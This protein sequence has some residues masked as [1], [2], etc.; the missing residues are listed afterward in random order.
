MAPKANKLL[1]ELAASENGASSSGPATKKRRQLNRRD[2]ED[3]VSRNIRDHFSDLTAV[4]TDGTTRGGLTLRQRLSNEH[5]E[6][7]SD[8]S[9]MSTAVFKELRAEYTSPEDPVRH[10]KIEKPDDP[11]N[12][13]FMTALQISESSNPAKRSKAPLYAYLATCAALNQKKLVVLL[14]SIIGTNPKTNVS[15][16]KHIVEV[17]RFVVRLNLDINF[18][19]EVGKLRHIFDETMA[20]TWCALKASGMSL[21]SFGTHT[22]CSSG[23]L[24]V[25]RTSKRSSRKM[26]TSRTSKKR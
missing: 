13:D 21:E 19:I 5:R 23:P 17:L 22:V 16:R 8:G 12:P 1:A 14:R 26:R 25:P 2:T 24:G 18:P 20:L 11:F 4:D 9:R 3:K 6:R 10:L 15:T 7:A